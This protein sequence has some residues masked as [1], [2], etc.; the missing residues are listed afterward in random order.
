LIEDIIADINKALK[1][2]ED[3]GVS[4]KNA[5]KIFATK[6][7]YSGGQIAT[8]QD[9]VSPRVLS[10]KE[11]EIKNGVFIQRLGINLFQIRYKDERTLVDLNLKINEHFSMSYTLPFMQIGYGIP[12][13]LM[14]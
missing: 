4:H 13:T 1:E 5:Q 11:I 3:A 9:I 14:T 2:I 8:M 7:H 10:D 6:L 12:M